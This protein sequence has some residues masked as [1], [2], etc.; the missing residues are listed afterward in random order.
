MKDIAQQL[1]EQIDDT[2]YGAPTKIPYCT[3]CKTPEFLIETAGYWYCLK[4]TGDE[5][6]FLDPIPEWVRQEVFAQN[7][8]K[9]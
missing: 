7:K 8:L 6:V 5:V 9:I 3:K 1:K 2:D 4:C